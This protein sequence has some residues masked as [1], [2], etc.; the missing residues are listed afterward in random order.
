MLRRSKG[1]GISSWPKSK[2][3]EFLVQ[4]PKS[5]NSKGSFGTRN[6][7]FSWQPTMRNLQKKLGKLISTQCGG[8]TSVTSNAIMQHSRNS[9]FTQWTSTIQL[10]KTSRHEETTFSHLSNRSQRLHMTLS[11]LVAGSIPSKTELHQS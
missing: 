9:N 10:V 11:I 1:Y 5:F 7:F 4:T 6:S 8:T 2:P 3:L